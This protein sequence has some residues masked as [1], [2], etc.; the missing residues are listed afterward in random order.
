MDWLTT[1]ISHALLLSG[2]E[3]NYS[4]GTVLRTYDRLVGRCSAA[5][6]HTAIAGCRQSQTGADCLRR[7]TFSTV[8]GGGCSTC[9]HHPASLSYQSPLHA[10]P[11]YQTCQQHAQ[12]SLEHAGH[13]PMLPAIERQAA[14]KTHQTI[15][16]LQQ[17][18][19]SSC[20]ASSSAKRLR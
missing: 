14:E 12:S 16:W 4:T 17:Q 18:H 5:L 3:A 13:H 1:L 9:H 15:S 11:A 8:E 20:S 7:L 2:K 19:S 6:T 10:A